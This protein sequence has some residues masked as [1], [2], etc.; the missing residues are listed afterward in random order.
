MYELE[1]A[2]DDTTFAL[3]FLLQLILLI[4]FLRMAWNIGKIRKHFVRDN[5]EALLQQANK[6][7]FKGKKDE[8]ID[9]YMDCIYLAKESKSE[10]NADEMKNRIIKSLQAIQN[11]GGKIPDGYEDYLKPLEKNETLLFK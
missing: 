6:F 8:A 3:T 5:Y 9:V 4:V 2:F 10:M 7:E 1:K 11:L